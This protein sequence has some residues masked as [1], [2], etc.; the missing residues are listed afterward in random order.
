MTEAAELSIYI[1]KVTVYS[2]FIS[3]Y[4]YWFI[5]IL[6]NS[7]VNQIQFIRKSVWCAFTVW[8]V[9][10]NMFYSADIY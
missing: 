7:V 3:D 8:W 2:I 10:Y 6:Y 4:K 9:Y 5:C 1:K